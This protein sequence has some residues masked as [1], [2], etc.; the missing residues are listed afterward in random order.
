MEIKRKA[1]PLALL[2]S[3]ILVSTVVL[4]LTVLADS[5][6]VNLTESITVEKVVL[7]AGAY[8]V[9]WTGDGPDVDV[10]FVNDGKTMVTA[11]AKLVFEKTRYGH[12][13]IETTTMPDKSKVLTKL[14]FSD[15][16]LIFE[17]PAVD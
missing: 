16:A 9:V 10:S 11:K 14:V 5:K 12:D 8:N 3:A 1:M 17:S 2:F 4:T 15:R 7:K 13:A 6:R